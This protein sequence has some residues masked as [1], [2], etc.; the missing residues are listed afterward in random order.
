[1]VR[2][3]SAVDNWYIKDNTRNTSNPIT[4]QLFANLTNTTNTNSASYIDFLSNGFKIRGTD[5]GTNTDG[6]TVIYMA[7][8]HQPFVTSGGVPCTA[9]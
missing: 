9:R 8:A 4:E 1:M 3:S 6:G 7:F 5:A 2:L